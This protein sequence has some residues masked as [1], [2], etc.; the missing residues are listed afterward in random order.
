MDMFEPQDHPNDFAYPGGPPRPPY[1]NAGY[2]L[3]YMMGVQFDRILEGFDC[4]CVKIEGMASPPAGTV[5]SASGSRGLLLSHSA[6]DAF[7]AVNRALKAGA[8][9]YWLKT[10]MTVNGQAYPSGSFYIEASGNVRNVAEQAAKDLGLS[11]D[12]T[13]EAPSAGAVKL[14][15]Q[16]VA[17]WDQ[18]GGSMPSG[19]TRWLLEQFEF[20]FDVVYPAAFDAG[21][22]RQKYDVI[23]FVTGAIPAARPDAQAASGGRG[24]GGGGGRGAVNAA[25]IPEEFRAWLGR[26][27]PERTLPQLKKFL[28]EGGT[29]ITIGSSTNLAEHLG[30]PVKDY[31]VERTP[32]G[33]ERPLPREKFYIPGSVMQVAVNN[34]LPIAA[35]IGKK[36][37]V[38][39]DES[40]VFRLE[41]DA[42]LRGVRPIAW[43]DSAHSLRSGWAWGQNYLQ[44]GVAMAEADVGRGKLYLF[45]PEI[46]FRAQPHGTFKFLFNG[47]Y[48]GAIETGDVRTI[49]P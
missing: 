49:Q 23:V 5:A 1:D 19:Q 3:A 14:K 4:P 38:F 40:P 29:I 6:N 7:T 44:G 48:G 31:M 42:G 35:G 18:Y 22:L 46:L 20:P 9:V 47:I 28:D 41:P 15:T 39:F 32:T 43:Y 21:N 25:D 45:G 13:A 10:P 36:A 24:G 17:L 34:T 2:T 30:L 12:G 37:D 11:F 27:T 16:R 26:I 33:E 8:S